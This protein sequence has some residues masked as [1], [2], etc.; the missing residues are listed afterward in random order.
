MFSGAVLAAEGTQNSVYIDYHDSKSTVIAAN[1][2]SAEV[3][4]PSDSSALPMMMSVGA[5]SPTGGSYP[6]SIKYGEISVTPTID[7][8]YGY[9]DNVTRAS[10]NKISSSVIGISPQIAAFVDRGSHKYTLTYAGDFIYLPSSTIDNRNTNNLILEGDHVFTTRNRLNWALTYVNGAEARGI[11][12]SSRLAGNTFDPDEFRSYQAK[13][14]YRYGAEG[15]KGNVELKSTY[16]D[17]KYLNNRATTITRDYSSFNYGA[18][19]LYRLSPKTQIVL[20]LNRTNIDYKSP[21]STQDS[22]EDKYLIGARWKALA[23]TEGYFKIGRGSKDF[24]T[25][26]IPS[27]STA[28]YESGVKWSPRTYSNFELNLDRSYVD[29]SSDITPAGVSRTIDVN[30]NHQWKSYFRT[31]ASAGFNK[32]DYN[33]GG[34]SDKTDTYKLSATYDVKRW[35][36]LGVDYTYEKRDSSDSNFAYKSNVLFFNASFSL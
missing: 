20:D 15:A 26:G 7:L 8:R 29:G 18:E 1:D 25:A 23:K 14:L 27:A 19:M 6:A 32:T 2:S 3:T 13:G 33:Q 36:G 22:T 28:V 17:K 4:S 35:F 12:D 9:D 30:W 24:D 31:V 10:V 11:T 5:I 16:L 21:L 34:R